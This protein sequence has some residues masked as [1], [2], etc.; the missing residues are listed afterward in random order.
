[1]DGSFKLAPREV[2]VQRRVIAVYAEQ[3]W[4]VHVLSQPRAVTGTTGTADLLVFTPHGI[5]WHEVKTATG[6]QRATQRVFQRRVEAVG[7]AYIL[8]GVAAAEAFVASPATISLYDL[9][10][11]VGFLEGEGSFTA[12]SNRFHITVSQVQRAPLLRARRIMGGRLYLK[13][14]RTTLGSGGQIIKHQPIHCLYLI[15]TEARRWMCR[16]QPLMSPRRQR[17]IQ[18][19]L[20]ASQD[21]R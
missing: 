11:L 15:G 14:A 16:L 1:M 12:L 18:K 20:D 7:M 21:A 9:G 5:L 19:V 3:G 17:Q 6:K 2:T 13:P 4:P 10:W 8:G